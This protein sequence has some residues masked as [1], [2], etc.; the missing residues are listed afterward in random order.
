MGCKRGPFP[1][2]KTDG[3]S[4]GEKGGTKGYERTRDV[5]S[6]RLTKQRP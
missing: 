5:G 6:G 4:K 1:A 2:G 3:G